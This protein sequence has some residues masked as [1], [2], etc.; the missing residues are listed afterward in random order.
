MD[1]QQAP[2]RRVFV[3]QGL[4]CGARGSRLLLG[5]LQARLAHCRDVRVEPWWCF[6]GCPHGP[7][8]VLHPDHAWYERV[9]P[10]DVEDIARHAEMG[11]P[12][13]REYGSRV[14]PVVRDNA[15]AALDRE[16]P[17]VTD[18]SGAA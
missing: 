2:A 10:E 6:N 13:G 17:P 4:F 1:S 18:A 8:V 16:H 15:F 14:P 9:L 5:Q 7:N 3:C 12:M 11:E